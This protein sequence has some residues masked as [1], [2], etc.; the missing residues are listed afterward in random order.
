MNDIKRICGECQVDITPLKNVSLGQVRDYHG[1]CF[2][3][4]CS[5]CAPKVE[6]LLR[7]IPGAPVY[8][9]DGRVLAS[10]CHSPR[11]HS[12]D[13]LKKVSYGTGRN[14]ARGNSKQVLHLV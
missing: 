7:R 8:S 13:E 3:L 5:R 14:S 11:I 1:N 9:R 2:A 12:L 6:N 4:V 10:A